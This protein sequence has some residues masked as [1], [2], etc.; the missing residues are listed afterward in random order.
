M[1]PLARPC[2]LIFNWVPRV[3]QIDATLV[4]SAYGHYEIDTDSPPRP[5]PIVANPSARPEP[6]P[7]RS[8]SQ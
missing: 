6:L 3:N 8:S 1:S 2:R 7:T 5:L 4:I